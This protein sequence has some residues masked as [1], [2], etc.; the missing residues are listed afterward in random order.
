MAAQFSSKDFRAALSSF[1]TGVTI[2]T[3]RDLKDEPIGMTASSFNSVSMEPPLVLWSI[4]KSALS[5]PSF[6]NAEFFAV[7]VLASD[8][9]E[10]SNKFAIKGEDKFSNI[11]WSQDSNGVPIIDGVSSRFDCKTYAIHEGGDHWIILGEVI[12]IENNSKRG[13]VFSEGSYSTTSAIRPNNQIPNELDTGSNLIDELLIYQLARASRQVENLF[14][15]TVDEEELTI[16]EWRILAS[17]Y[18]NAS[19]SLSEL[20][21]RTFVDPGVIID[22]L[23]RMSI[24]NLCTLSDTKSEMIITGTNDGM[25]RVANLFDAAQNQENAILTDLNEIE[26][27]ALIKQL[28]SIIRT[29]NN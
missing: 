23:T 29:T 3:A 17:L 9:T 27:V 24:D 18:G 11:N 15:K 19:R 21:A 8:Q 2:I 26:R 25:K 28:K 14:H 12:E 22:I 20:C 5:A 1:A 6:T 10:I 4:A 7:H 16:P 13:L